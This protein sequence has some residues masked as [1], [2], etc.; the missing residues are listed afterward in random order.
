[1]QKLNDAF[2]TGARAVQESERGW[3]TELSSPAEGA[4]VG[5]DSGGRSCALFWVIDP[6]LL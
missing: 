2:Q 1:M 4:P 3:L 5:M 6:H